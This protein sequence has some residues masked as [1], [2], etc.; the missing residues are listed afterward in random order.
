MLLKSELKEFPLS[1]LPEK[2]KKAEIKKENYTYYATASTANLKRSGEI[3]CVDY[4]DI[5]TR[6]LQVR[7]FADKGKRNY[8]SYLPA[9]DTWMKQALCRCLSRDTYARDVNA[10]STEEDCKTASNY[11][12]NK[13]KNQHACNWDYYAKGIIAVCEKFCQDI[14]DDKCIRAL[15]NKD[16]RDKYLHSLFTDERKDGAEEFCIKNNIWNTNYLFFSNLSKYKSRTGVCSACGKVMELDKDI[17]H[18][19]VSYCPRCYAKVTYCA[20]RYAGSKIDKET[21]L[22][23]GKKDGQ[24]TFEL[25][26]AYRSFD[27]ELNAKVSFVPFKRNVLSAKGKMLGSVLNA[28]SY[29][30]GDWWSR[31]KGWSINGDHITYC[32]DPDTVFDKKIGNVDFAEVIRYGNF[33]GNICKLL[34]NLYTYP[35]CEYLFKLGLRYFATFYAPGLLNT[36]GKT[37][38]QVM[39]VNKAYLPM[40]QAMDIKPFEHEVIKLAKDFVTEDMI[41]QFRMIPHHSGDLDRM[42]EILSHM[43]FYKFLAYHQKQREVL[44]RLGTGCSADITMYLYDYIGM[45]KELGI[46]LS[47]SNLFP[48]DIKKAHDQLQERITVIRN[49][50]KDRESREKLKAV[51]SFF[52]GYAKDG[53]TVRLPHKRSDLIIEG[54]KLSHCVGRDN[55]YNNHIK[56]DRMIFFIR[57]AE[58]PDEP[59]FTCE[60]NMKT[61]SIIQLYG[62]G[63]C[64]APK[65]VRKFVEGFCKWLKTHHKPKE[66][67]KAS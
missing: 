66:I 30:Y 54:Q 1:E 21:I 67:K 52:T 16:D 25:N 31:Y 65:E 44:R 60:I 58:E 14:R 26:T 40:Y 56:G 63:D 34:V 35:E 11:L 23:L 10:Y 6:K 4:Y 49:E 55:Y 8:I 3:L 53:F 32:H 38:S 36:K 50:K 24:I 18:N 43:T 27:K 59:Y 28:R 57:K 13:A 45:S 46:S 51:N 41:E 22:L 64:H 9:E 61:Y 2:L 29:Y 7:F 42:K 62:F 19:E 12:G 17:K 15:N 48:K 5:E 47:K 39:G 33:R 37:F 20:E